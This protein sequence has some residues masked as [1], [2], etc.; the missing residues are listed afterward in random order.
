MAYFRETRNVELSTIEFLTAQINASWTGVTTVKTFQ[1][2]E[3]AK[4]PVVCIRLLDTLS[5]TREIGQTLLA[6][7]YNIVIDIFAKSDG[8]RLDLADFI[9][10]LIPDG[11]VYYEYS[12][13]PGHPDQLSTS[14][15]GRV[16]FQSILENRRIDFYETIEDQDKYRHIISFL[17]RK[18]V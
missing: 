3:A 6:H 15:A 10:N 7:N 4:L 1:E 9:T 2:A 5:T 13:T 14:A 11:W 12:H 8:Q 16:N 17:V 18:H